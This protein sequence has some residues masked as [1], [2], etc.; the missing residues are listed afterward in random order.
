MDVTIGDDGEVTIDH[1]QDGSSAPAPPARLLHSPARF[2]T[3]ILMWLL[4]GVVATA[5]LSETSPSQWLS[6][7]YHDDPRAYRAVLLFASPGLTALAA[8]WFV[9]AAVRRVR[10]YRAQQN[11]EAGRKLQTAADIDSA[12]KPYA[13]L[14]SVGVALTVCFVAVFAFALA[15]YVAAKEDW[16]L[17]TVEG[18]ILIV[19]ARVATWLLAAALPRRAARRRVDA[20]AR[21]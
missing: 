3:P 17:V 16:A 20:S 15:G 7:H 19:I 1:T 9:V 2:I 13:V 18:V 21:D 12:Q 5:I 11:S 4:V 10:P 6:T 14:L 8:L